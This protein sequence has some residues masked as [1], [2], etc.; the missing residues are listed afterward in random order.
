MRL[1]DKA[2]PMAGKTKIEFNIVNLDYDEHTSSTKD[3][4]KIGV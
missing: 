1:G 2:T 4:S 3:N